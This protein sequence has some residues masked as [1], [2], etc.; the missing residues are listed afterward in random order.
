MDAAFECCPHKYGGK[1]GIME[2]VQLN[3]EIRIDL[4]KARGK[5]AIGNLTSMFESGM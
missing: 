1:Q 3:H 4:Q 5:T 2:S